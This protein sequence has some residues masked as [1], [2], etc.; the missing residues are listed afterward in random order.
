M[1]QTRP[2]LDD[3]QAAE[4]QAYASAWHLTF[5]TAVKILLRAGLDAA[6]IPRKEEKP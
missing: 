1:T 2:R 6:P 3:D 4:V 5:S